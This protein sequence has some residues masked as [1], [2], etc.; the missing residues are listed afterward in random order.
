MAE[1]QTATDPPEPAPRRRGRGAD[2]EE[3]KA[4]LVT[5]A[6]ESLVEDGYRGTTARA[7]G[8]RANCNQAAIYYHFGGIDALLIAAL[9]K[10][11]AE[12]LA[13]YEAAMPEASTLPE[14][15]ALIE[16]LYFED[17]KSG[18]LS[19]LAELTGGIT[20]APELRAGIDS[21]TRPWL[22]FVEGQIVETAKTVSFGAMLPA[23]DLADLVFSIVIGV[24]LRNR[25][26]ESPDR[27]ERL[28]RLAGLASAL[29]ESGTAKA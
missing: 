17:S 25:I 28:F 14:L 13:R 9:H 23:R 16:E 10:S 11:S 18:H 19:V 26:D 22:D 2:P 1:D 27:A 20:A 29:V 8:Q 3:T 15:V 5:A 21:A 12:R 24:E 4:Q 6:I 7:I